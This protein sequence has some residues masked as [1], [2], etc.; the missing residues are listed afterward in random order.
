MATTQVHPPGKSVP[1]VVRVK[2]SADEE[3]LDVIRLLPP[4]SKIARG[5]NSSFSLQNLEF[6]HAG[7]IDGNVSYVFEAQKCKFAR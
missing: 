1:L 5:S 7:T 3:P 6:K 2:R 4:P